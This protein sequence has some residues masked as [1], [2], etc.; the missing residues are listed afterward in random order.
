[1]SS[2]AAMRIARVAFVLLPLL[3]TGCTGKGGGG[4]GSAGGS[5][6]GSDAAPVKLSPADMAGMEK[7]DATGKF[8]GRITE[9]LTSDPKTFNPL[10]SKETSGGQIIA[11]VFDG[12]VTRNADTLKIEA[13]LAESWTTSPD[14]KSWTFKLRKGIK[15]SDGQPFTADDVIFTLDAIYD[16]KVDTTLKDVLKVNGKPWTYKKID[17]NTVQIDLPET[18][19]LL[20]DVAGFPILPKHKLEAAKTAG[21][22][23]STWGIDMKPSELVG[24]GPFVL[25]SFKPGESVIMKR[26]PYYWKLDS[27]GKQLP[28][29]DGIVTEIVP[30]QNAQVLKFTSKQKEIDYTVLRPEDWNS[31]NA[32]ASSG[33]YKAFDLGPTWGFSYLGLNQNPRATAVPAYKREWFSTKEFRQAVSYAIDRDAMVATVLRGL[34]VPLWSPVSSA[35]TTFYDPNIKKYPH[36]PAKAKALLAGLGMTDKKGTGV[37]EDKAGHP[38]EFTLLVSNSSNVAVSLATLLKDNLKQ[39]GINVDVKPMQ[40]NSITTKLGSSFDWE[41]VM[42]GFTGGPE[43]YTGKTI[44]LSSGRLHP[45]NPQEPSPA[46]PWEAEIDKIFTEAGREP[47]TAK[48]KA[49]Y[50][51]FQGIVAEQQPIIFLATS[52]Y[53]C[54]VRNRLANTKPTALGGLRW[55]VYEI[56]EH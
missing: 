13:D 27:T 29:V 9:A 21:Q 28:F 45:W 2:L 31:V 16:D 56:S 54:A 20:L 26:N 44:W 22:L 5:G 43:P 41:A 4:N 50:S 23:N 48:R 38:V 39:V 7:T 52:K 42:L 11:L 18:F 37:L 12:L 36:D 1:M 3:L 30:D 14:A 34:G 33:D 55:N 46:T 19:G 53:L 49:L 40:F 6:A 24:T 10:I 17:D 47:D 8:G 35:N 32:G 15:W 51:R 25:A